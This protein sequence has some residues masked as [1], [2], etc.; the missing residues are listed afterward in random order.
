MFTKSAV[1]TFSNLAPRN[2][3]GR[4]AFDHATE[5]GRRFCGSRLP[6]PTEND[7]VEVGAYISRCRLDR[8]TARFF[9]RCW[10][11]GQ[12]RLHPFRHIYRSV[13]SVGRYAP[14]AGTRYLT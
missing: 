7:N 13:F 8:G 1:L 10:G 5:I 3:L 4:L 12:Y 9:W 2:A 14:D 11:R 6:I